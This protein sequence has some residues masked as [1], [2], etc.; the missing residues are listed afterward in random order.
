[1]MTMMTDFKSVQISTVQY[2]SINLR[3]KQHKC[4]LQSQH[5]NTDTTNTSNK[6]IQ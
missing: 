3:A 1:M 6:N 5:N 2:V 4:Q